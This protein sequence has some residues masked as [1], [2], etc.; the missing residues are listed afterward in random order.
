MLT[1]YVVKGP[2][3]LTSTIGSYMTSVFWG[4]FAAAR[5]ASI[6]LAIWFSNLQMIIFDIVICITG[7][8]ILVIFGASDIWAVWLATVLLGVGTAS[9]FPAAVGWTDRYITMTNKI[10]SS[11]SIGASF[12]EMVIPYIIGIYIN[13]V[14]EIL[15]YMVAASSILSVVVILILWLILRKQQDKY[16]KEEG[17]TNVAVDA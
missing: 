6:F 15:T 8:L 3:K 11:F 14:P 5:F 16:L 1:T 12:G 13:T 10:A 4:S 9:F 2:L 17:T 7:A